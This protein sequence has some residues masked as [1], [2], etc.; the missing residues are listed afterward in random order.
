MARACLNRMSAQPSLML[1]E[2]VNPTQSILQSYHKNTTPSMTDNSV[3]Q[4]A[5]EVSSVLVVYME[6]HSVNTHAL[7]TFDNYFGGE[8]IEMPEEEEAP[9]WG[10]TF[11]DSWYGFYL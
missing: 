3:G 2:V 10:P 4:N 11:V 7:A 9:S 6:C 1:A 5:A 8:G